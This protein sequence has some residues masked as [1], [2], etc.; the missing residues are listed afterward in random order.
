MHEVQK[1]AILSDH[2]YLGYAVIT[3]KKFWDGLPADV[4]AG[5][6]AA[7]A[8]ATV[9]ANQIA[10]QENDEALAKV[11]A[12]GKTEIYVPTAQDKAAWKKALVPV[13]KEMESRIGK[14]TIQAVYSA[15]GF[16]PN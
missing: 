8:E 2:G 7:M 11:K 9:Y 6:E 10:K 16:K 13:H 14:D 3:N 12:S 1:H 5:L 4:R 15:T